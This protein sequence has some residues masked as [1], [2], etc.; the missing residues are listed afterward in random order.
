MV[1]KRQ[2]LGPCNA[3][4]SLWGMPMACHSVGG[5]QHRAK[6]PSVSLTYFVLE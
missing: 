2:R 1:G 4:I 6:Q 3:Q 5:F